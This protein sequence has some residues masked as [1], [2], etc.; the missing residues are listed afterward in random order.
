MK[1]QN[2][3]LTVATAVAM[4]LAACASQPPANDDLERARTAV[5]QV[6]S[7]PDAGKYAAEEVTAAHNALREA[8]ALAAKKKPAKDIQQAAYLAQRHADIAGERIARGQAEAKTAAAEAERQK[9]I[10]QAR[11]KEAATA[12]SQAEMA[13]SQADA[14]RT[15]AEASQQQAQAS[16]QQALASQQRA[17]AS[18][19]QAESANEQARLAAEAAQRK[20]ADMEAQLRD[21]QAK[22]TDRGMVLTLG[23]VL[24]DTGQSALKPGAG[25]T[26]DRLGTFL[27]EAADRSVTIE[28]HT[29]S[30]GSE[31]TNQMLSESRANA[32][33]AA[34]VAKGIAAERI[35]SVGK[36]EAVPVASNET[37]A[38]RQQNRR[39]EIIISNPSG[40][41]KIAGQ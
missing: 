1:F 40:T 12:R 37:S 10:L 4:A 32:V 34:L 9:V 7:S 20:A 26:M 2:S 39:V 38:G 31:N 24:F 33:K 35:V 3:R 17:E 27:A 36:G 25:S 15:Q 5:L 18:Q 6:E 29:D 41:Q 13:R 11:E 14:A 30:M 16:Q 19:Q 21:L 8:D 28:G 23:D 22:Q